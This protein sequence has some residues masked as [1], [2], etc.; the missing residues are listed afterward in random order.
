MSHSRA[1]TLLA[2]GLSYFSFES[3]FNETMIMLYQVKCCHLR[4][5]NRSLLQL[6]FVVMFYLLFN[7]HKCWAG[8][9]EDLFAKIQALP[10]NHEDIEAVNILHCIQ[11]EAWKVA[12][13]T[14]TD[15]LEK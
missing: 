2:R 1:Q 8:L 15:Q 14:S 12:R 3:F 6:H 9:N 4:P 11:D 13:E 7:V 5:R 10:D